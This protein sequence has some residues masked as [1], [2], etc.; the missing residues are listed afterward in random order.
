MPKIECMPA[1][2]DR[3]PKANPDVRCCWVCGRPGGYGFTEALRG[4]GYR[5]PDHTIGYAHATCMRRAASE[6]AKRELTR[7]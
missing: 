1:Y 4:A 3:Y 6:A 2:R 5:M 7:R